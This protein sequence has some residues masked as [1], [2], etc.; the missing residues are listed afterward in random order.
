MTP[1]IHCPVCDIEFSTERPSIALPFCS[2]RCKCIDRGR[3]VNE[4]YGLPYE[5]EHEPPFEQEES[6][7]EKREA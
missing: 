7:S 4:E 5:S 1:Q 2:K 6:G 3:W